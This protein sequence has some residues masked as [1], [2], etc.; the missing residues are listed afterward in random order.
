MAIEDAAT[1]GVVRETVFAAGDY[2]ASP[3]LMSNTL[4]QDYCMPLTP[5]FMTEKQMRAATARGCEP[6]PCSR[7]NSVPLISSVC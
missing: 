4:F 2:P 7:S 6:E 1:L 3:N 5:G